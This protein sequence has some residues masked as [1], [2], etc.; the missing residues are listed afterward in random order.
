MDDNANGNVECTCG[1]EPPK[2]IKYRY[3][4][5]A[6]QVVVNGR[7][8]TSV[9]TEWKI[10]DR[11]G[12]ALVRLGFRRMN[13][14][15]KP[16]LYA[17]G[18]PGPASPVAVSANYKLSF[19]VLRREMKGMNAWMLVIDTKGVNVWC[20]A[21]KGT[22]GTKEIVRMIMETKLAEVVSHRKLVVPQLGAPGVAAGLVQM[23]SEFEVIYGP[24]RAMDLRKFVENGMKAGREMRLVKFGL[25][26]RMTVALL[27]FAVAARIGIA[28]TAAALA[29]AG[30][31]SGI[32]FT[33]EVIAVSTWVSIITGTLL[34]PALLAALPG[35]AF[36]VKGGLAGAL[37]GLIT[38]V[39]YGLGA[40][41]AV[42]V[43]LSVGAASA[44]MASTFT[45]ASTYTSLSGV[46]KELKYAIPTIIALLVIAGA[47]AVI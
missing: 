38:A 9:S 30:V 20:A 16:G 40:M 12:E 42:S 39:L 15:V 4:E 10:A 36:S 35:R 25:S 34:T 33:A 22:F 6:G 8:I 44:F 43:T 32:S 17:V 41:T 45:G 14:A 5:P 23:M 7:E 26:D 3:I 46:R 28:V 27:D 47:L 18:R 29:A 2:N 1:S 13:Y 37:T 24:V 21:G 19:D 31:F 11:L